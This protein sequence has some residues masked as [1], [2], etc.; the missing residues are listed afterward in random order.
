MFPAALRAL[1]SDRGRS[2]KMW[3]LA[4]VLVSLGAWMAWQNAHFALGYWG[5]MEDPAT[6]DGRVITL[7]LHKVVAIE[8]GSYRIQKFA[9]PVPVIGPVNGL[10]IGTVVSVQGHFDARRS[11]VIEDFRMVHGLRSLKY[12]LGFVG[13]AGLSVYFGKT[14]RWRG[15]RL[16]IRA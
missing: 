15:G 9:E 2:W 5:C 10:A 4:L 8:D 12:L 3:T 11:A 14:L 7:S 13:L 6:N 16:V 1:L